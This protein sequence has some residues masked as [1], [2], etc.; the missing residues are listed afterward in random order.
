[1]FLSIK[2]LF[3]DSLLAIICLVE[4]SCTVVYVPMDR[5]TGCVCLYP[6][7]GE[8]QRDHTHSIGECMYLGA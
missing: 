5:V 2:Y 6:L 8:I 1:M 4:L 7:F 3:N